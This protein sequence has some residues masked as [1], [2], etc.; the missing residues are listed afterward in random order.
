[1][2][3]IEAL[4]GPAAIARLRH[5]DALLTQAAEALRT[6]PEAVPE[7]VVALQRERKELER[8]V[9]SASPAGGVDVDALASSA[10]VLSDAKVLVCEI[11][12]PD[13]DAMLTAVDRLK[14]KLDDAAIVLGSRGGGKSQFVASVSPSL[15]E[16]GLKA[17]DIVRVAAKV[18]G[19]GGGGRDTLARAGGRDPEK[20]PDALNAARRAIEAAL[21]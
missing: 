12:V 3:R 8:A 21:G 18:T 16:R 20:L 14:G 4:S 13:M 17:G 19:G 10:R 7:A 2:R 15:V 5:H 11:E 6:Q 9:R 1:V